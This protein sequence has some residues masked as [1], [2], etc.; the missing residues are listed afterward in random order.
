MRGILVVLICAGF[1]HA[2]DVQWVYFESTETGNGAVLKLE[3]PDGSKKDLAVASDTVMLQY[4]ERFIGAG[5]K[6][7]SVD[8]ADKNR[9]LMRFETPNVD[10]VQKAEL[11][12]QMKLSQTPPRGEFTIAV[13]NV[14]TAWNEQWVRWPLQPD[15]DTQAK[16]TVTLKPREQVVR[17][18]MTDL[19]NEWLGKQTPNHGICIRVDRPFPVGEKRGVQPKAVPNVRANRKENFE[20]DWIWIAS[21][22]AANGPRLVVETEDGKKREIAAAADAGVISYLADRK[23]GRLK[24]MGIS[25]N[26]SNRILLRFDMPPK[27]GKVKKA[28]LRLDTKVQP[29]NPPQ[30]FDVALHPLTKAWGE[31]DTD[32]LTQPKMAQN[33]AATFAVEP[34]KRAQTLDFDV[35]DVV[36]NKT[37]LEHGWLLKVAKPL[38]KADVRK[39]QRA[40]RAAQQILLQKHDLK[41]LA[42]VDAASRSW[43]GRTTSTSPR[44]APSS[45]WR[46][47]SSTPT[48][49]RSSRSASSRSASPTTAW[50]TRPAPAHRPACASSA[51]RSPTPRRPRSSSATRPAST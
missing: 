6:R 49:A 32:W 15:Y 13:H 35:T 36:K 16:E 34:I 23:W 29:M 41:W 40:Q 5:H 47:R 44:S 7:L 28:T 25:L 20:T 4:I 24:F 30:K 38:G 37:G 50:P 14:K 12:L 21:R 10:R 45:S 22:E 3:M 48:S 11:V 1:A 8:L 2:Q 51:R 17:I 33:A 26:D 42:S 18:P 39:D 19:V 9:T 43:T 27:M 46:R 31:M